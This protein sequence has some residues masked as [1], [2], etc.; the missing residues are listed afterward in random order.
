MSFQNHRSSGKRAGAAMAAYFTASVT[1]TTA[2]TAATGTAATTAS[3]RCRKK[4][5]K[6]CCLL[7]RPSSCYGVRLQT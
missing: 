5:P 6:Q 7:Q 3:D 1:A 2:T 4:L